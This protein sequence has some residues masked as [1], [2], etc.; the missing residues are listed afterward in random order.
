MYLDDARISVSVTSV[1]LLPKDGGT[2]LVVTEQGAHLDGL[3]D[4]APRERGTSSQLDALGA[5]LERSRPAPG[6]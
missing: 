5:L 2:R 6:R 1:E 4:P 3:D